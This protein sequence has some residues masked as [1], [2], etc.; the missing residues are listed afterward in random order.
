MK[1]VTWHATSVR[2][3]LERV[4]QARGNVCKS[5]SRQTQAALPASEYNSQLAAAAQLQSSHCNN[6]S[7]ATTIEHADS[8]KH[9]TDNRDDFRSLT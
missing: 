2:Y 3:S 9:N 8:T 5:S 4:K 7:T 6:R 1:L